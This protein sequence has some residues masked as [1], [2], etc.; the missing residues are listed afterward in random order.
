MKISLILLSIL[1]VRTSSA[2]FFIEPYLGIG[3][4]ETE[5]ENGVF[6]SKD[7]ANGFHLGLRGGLTYDKYFFGGEYFRGGPYNFEDDLFGDTEL[8][9]SLIGVVLGGDFDVIRV[10][11]AYFL[12]YQTEDSLNNRTLLGG[13]FRVGFGLTVGKKIRANLDVI[14]HTMDKQRTGTTETDL[15]T[16]IKAQNAMVSISFPIDIK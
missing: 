9:T 1:L 3:K 4:F 13:A 11:A 16:K 8:S 15:L 2:G 6:V 5:Q 7:I 12:D 14:F 10:S